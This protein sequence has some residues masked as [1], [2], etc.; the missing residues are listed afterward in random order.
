M[1]AYTLDVGRRHQGTERGKVV[2]HEAAS[3]AFYGDVSHALAF[4]F[5]GAFTAC[6]W[7]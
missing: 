7:A 3:V 5:F 1:H 6:C 4:N 2:V